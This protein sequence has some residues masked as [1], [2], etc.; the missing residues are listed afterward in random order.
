MGSSFL[1]CTCCR[2]IIACRDGDFTK[3]WQVSDPQNGAF[4]RIIACREDLDPFEIP[5][6]HEG[7]PM[8]EIPSLVLKLKI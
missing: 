8:P 6:S 3:E 2:D 4:V 7:M 5:H 1:F